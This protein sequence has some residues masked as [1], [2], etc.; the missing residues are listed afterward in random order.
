MNAEDKCTTVIHKNGKLIIDQ[1]LLDLENE[2]ADVLVR[3]HRKTLVTK[4]CIRGLEK[5]PNGRHYLHLE[6][7]DE[8]LQ[9]SRRNLPTIRKLIRELT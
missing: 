4:K 2:H 5:T 1:S 7:Y 3:I 9:V 6:G 8:R